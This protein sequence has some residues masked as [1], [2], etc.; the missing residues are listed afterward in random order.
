M[1]PVIKIQK[2]TAGEDG[3]QQE[4]SFI[5]AGNVKQCKHFG[6]QFGSLLPNPTLLCFDGTVNP[7][8]MFVLTYCANVDADF[9]QNHKH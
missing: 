3:A 5:S 4:L 7:H 8:M 2:P 6:R 1:L 9:I